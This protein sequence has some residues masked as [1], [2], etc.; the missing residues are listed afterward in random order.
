ME[1]FKLHIKELTEEKDRLTLALE[2]AEATEDV[3]IKNIRDK[4]KDE[5][6]DLNAKVVLLT[7]ENGTLKKQFEESEKYARKIETDNVGLRKE[8]EL[9][10]NEFVS[11]E[12]KHAEIKDENRHLADEVS[13][14]PKRFSDLARHNQKLVKETAAM[15]YN[16]G[17]SHIKGKEYERAIKEFEKV[18]ELRPDD[19]AA[20][21]NLGYI[22]A[23][24]VVDRPLAIKYFQT[25]LAQAPDAHDADWVRK[26]IL[27]WKSWYG[28][29]KLK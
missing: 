3:K 26:Y 25:Y 22:F 21:Y 7:G 9:L 18:L 1:S 5:V 13:E 16:L 2:E 11:L 29:E 17:V 10:K 6:A 24:H 15:H 19:S 23:E 4:V 8:L 14:F 27:T 12:K 28:K 20:N